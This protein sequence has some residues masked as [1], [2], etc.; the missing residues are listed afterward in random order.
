MS[1][2]EALDS[3]EPRPPDDGKRGD[4][5]NYAERLSRG[6]AVA[7]A[8]ALRKEYPGVL[9]D[10]KGKKHESPAGGARGPKK[11]DVNYSTLELGLGLGVSIK[12][13]NHKDR[14]TKK[15]THNLSRI[16]DELRAEAMDYHIRQPFAVLV[17]VLFMP[18]HGFDD[19]TQVSSFGSAVKK[20]RLRAGREKP[21]EEPYLFE[22][23]F[24]GVYEYE[25]AQRG[26]VVFF[27]VMNAP[28]KRGRPPAHDLLTFEQLIREMDLAFRFRNNPP[29]EWGR[30]TS[31]NGLED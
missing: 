9:P 18:N 8:S 10:P 3:A 26:K 7:I 27:D 2:S 13:V 16:D 24:V 1:I 22:R 23:F 31:D 19:G 21:S 6:L 29:F 25:G 12:T 5:K 20:F 4:K 30:P 15:Y 11:L 17:G 28:P 14:R